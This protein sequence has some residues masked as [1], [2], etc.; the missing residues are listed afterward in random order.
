MD[1]GIGTWDSLSRFGSGI[2]MSDSSEHSHRTISIASNLTSSACSSASS[3]SQDSSSC[4]LGSC[5]EPDGGS[6]GGA[7]GGGGLRS[8][9]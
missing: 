1:P 4:C 7:G 6:S 3:L 2:S 5:S 8:K 9:I